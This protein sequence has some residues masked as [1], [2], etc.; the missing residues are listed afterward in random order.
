MRLVAIAGTRPELIKLR[1]IAAETPTSLI[2]TGQQ[3]H[4]AD[5]TAADWPGGGGTLLPL[6]CPSAGDPFAY[7]HALQAPL[8]TALRDQSPDWVLVQGDT[9]SAMAGALAASRLGLPVCHVEAGLRTYDLTDPYPEE[10]FRVQISRLATLHCA[11]TDH[12]AHALRAEGVPWERIAVTGNT[13]TDA[14]RGVRRANTRSGGGLLITLHRRESK[15]SIP[16]LVAALDRL[17]GQSEHPF[18]LIDH[19]NGYTRVPTSHLERLQPMPHNAFLRLLCESQAVLTDSG[20]LCEETTTLGIPCLIA[21][22]A[23]ERPEAVRVGSARLIGQSPENLEA[24]LA[25]ALNATISPRTVFG[26][27]HSA[28]RIIRLLTE[29]RH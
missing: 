18:R 25:W 15:D 3:P 9:A 20:G 26:D 4:L 2:H 16:A 11:P 12:A 6:S 19:P 23:T 10:T 8:K 21:R 27:G 24:D 13:S 17:A 29:W 14:L 7:V 22:N 5:A 28:P 1:P